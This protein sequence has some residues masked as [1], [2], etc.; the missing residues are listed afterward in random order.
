MF[1][2]RFD[3]NKNIFISFSSFILVIIFLELFVRLIINNGYN[4][5]LEMMKYSNKLKFPVIKKNNESYLA[6]YPN[7]KTKIMGVNIITDK[8][9]YRLTKKNNTKKKTILMLG[10]SMT[11]GFGSSLTFSDYLNNKLVDYN[12]INAGVGNTNTIMQVNSFFAKDYKTSPDIVVVNFFI[13]DL[14]R[15]KVR[16]KKFIDY[17]YLF[18]YIFYKYKIIKLKYKKNLDYIEYYKI[19]FQDHN[20]VTET[21]N[22]FLK[23]KNYCDKKNI[24]LFVNFIPEVRNIKYNYFFEEKKIIKNFLKKQNIK[25]IDGHTYFNRL[26]SNNFLVHIQDPHLNTKGHYVVYEYL[27]KFIL[28]NKKQ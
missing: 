25:F 14:E 2:N 12:V 13:N 21:F 17:S 1:R 24:D 4:Y 10:D 28:L 23:L 20:F 5:E 8:N 22:S 7:K 3:V 26:R 6:H 9:G 27:K 15:V 11:F 16:K 18:N 19:T